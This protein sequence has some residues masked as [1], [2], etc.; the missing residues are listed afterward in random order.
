MKGSR[1]QIMEVSVH[2][3]CVVVGSYVHRAH[4]RRHEEDNIKRRVS[5]CFQH[6]RS[7]SPRKFVSAEAEPARSDEIVLFIAEI[8]SGG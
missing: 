6:H 7:G 2:E 3:T 1:K 5:R 8:L 4:P